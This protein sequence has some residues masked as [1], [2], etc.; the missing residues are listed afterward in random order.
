M[1][2]KKLIRKL[3]TATKFFIKPII[4]YY[5]DKN[6][7]RIIDYSRYH[8]KLKI[9]NNLIFY[10][11][12]H[13]KNMVDSPLAIFLHLI[14]N[15]KYSKYKHVWAL[16]SL[17][18]CYDKKYLNHPRVKFVKVHSKEYLKYLCKSKFLINNTSFPTYFQK[19]EGQIYINTW[20]GTPLKTLGKHMKGVIG[21]HKNI[22]RNFLQSDYILHPNKYTADI[23]AESHDLNGIYTGKMVVE[24]YPRMDL[25]INSNRKNILDKLK[26][27]VDIKEDEKII[28]YAPTWRGEVNNVID[29]KDEIKDIINKMYN[30]MP[31]GYKLLLKIHTLAYKFVK[32]DSKLK[33]I[34][35]PDSF[36]TNELLSVVDILITDYS[37]IFFDYL[38]TGKPII[39]FVYDK[40]IYSEERGLYLNLDDLPGP[41]CTTVEEVINEIQNIDFYMEKYNHLY[42][43]ARKKY[44]YLDKGNTTSKIIEIIFE[45][46][47]YG[48]NVYQ[49]IDKDKINILMYCGGF[50]NNGI[51][52]SVI[53]LL[54]YI[55]YSKFNITVID[56]GKY[57]QISANNI[58]KL[59]SNV[60]MIYRDGNMNTTLK[61]LYCH[62]WIIKKGL[63]KPRFKKI[64]P[65]QLYKKELK[66]LLGNSRFDVVVDFSGYVPFWTLLF[67]IGDFRKKCIY[68]HNDMY[69]ESKKK[70]NGKYKH[71]NNLNI[72][73]PLY[74]YF[75]KI[76]SVGEYTKELNVSNLRQYIDPSKAT[77]VPNTIDYHYILDSSNR[78]EDISIN[79][80][81]YLVIN[82]FDEFG[83]K[84]FKCIKYPDK[85]KINFISIGRLSP[86]KDHEKL[87]KAFSLLY[88]T[89]NDVRL[90]IVG[91]G[92]LEERLKRLV[93]RMKI[94][95]NVIFTGQLS[96]PFV[97]L[98]YCDCLVLSSNHE[99]QPMVLLEALVL[100]KPVIA[101]DIPGNRSVLQ[102]RYG[103]L[104][105]NSV[106]GLLEGF[107]KFINR[108]YNKED[109][110]FIDYNNK[111][112][113]TFY[114]EVCS[115]D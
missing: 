8:K 49:I 52:S 42:N 94:E 5:R 85:T 20:H 48:K 12:F 56:K 60:K 100:K 39:Y 63:L 112:I 32:E 66:R 6:F 104:V 15:P 93:K 81:K 109:F 22:Q 91:E 46:N 34:C 2:I 107:L 47:E 59:N 18:N 33:E 21:Q 27:I 96:N 4:K 78:E 69:A 13:G 25:T 58:T 82:N 103:M 95:N 108:Q 98:K 23:I 83:T 90:Y 7:K 45:G 37:S 110:D 17:E 40:E 99:G 79:G 28:L 65:T 55:D 111:A 75:D 29:I 71:K 36:D 30:L 86:E 68:Q 3:I 31:K 41:K 16:N 38:V 84:D 97:L 89:R 24:G 106:E 10:E 101:T 76:I 26:N 72:I 35:I 14:D 1:S 19:K 62:N 114:N 61:E 11:S 105:E 73:F 92:V 70:I 9:D 87:I 80:E 64:I 74:K 54:N 44:C 113:D 53:N 50:L 43:L 88:N 51:T 102:G 115:I 67:A 57:D 77:L